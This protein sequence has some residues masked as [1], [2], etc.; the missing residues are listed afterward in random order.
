[1]PVT[2]GAVGDIIA[3]V[4]VVKDLVDALDKARGSKVQHQAAM[5]ELG[6][7]ERN[8]LEI[9]VLIRRHGDG[10]TPELQGLCELAKEYVATCNNLVTTYKDRVE[11]YRT[12]FDQAQAP[13]RLSEAFMA[14]RWRFE[15]KEALEKFRE[16]LG[17][18]VQNLQVL[19]ITVDMYAKITL[20]FS[21]ML[22][23]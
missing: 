16:E 13:K 22:I 23:P 21:S 2:F 3:V 1:M 9:G 5:R 4:L 19:M 14:I 11:K 12:T 15:E 20:L 6:L 17:G 7:L 8:L 10:A 18:L